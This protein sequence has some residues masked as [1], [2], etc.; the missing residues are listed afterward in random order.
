MAEDPNEMPS[1]DQIINRDNLLNWLNSRSGNTVDG[2]TK[3]LML[4]LAMRLF[5]LVLPILELDGPEQAEKHEKKL[6]LQSFRAL[7]TTRAALT[8]SDFN[9]RP[10]LDNVNRAIQKLKH[11]DQNGVSSCAA[12]LAAD[13][14]SCASYPKGQSGT[15]NRYK[16]Y[17]VNAAGFAINL[18]VEAASKIE[19]SGQAIQE[20]FA[21][22]TEDVRVIQD[23]GAA[24]D[25]LKRRLWLNDVRSHTPRRQAHNL[26]DWCRIPFN[27]FQKNRN[28]KGQPWEKIVEWYRRFLAFDE[29]KLRDGFGETVELGI[30]QLPDEIWDGD[31]DEA[32]AQIADIVDG[33]LEIPKPEISTNEGL[34]KSKLHEIGAGSTAISVDSAARQDLLNRRAFADQLCLLLQRLHREQGKALAAINTQRAEDRKPPVKGDGFA[35]NLYAPWGAGKTSI[36]YMMEDYFT[37]AQR[38]KNECW[39]AV[40]FNAWRHERRNPPW[41]PL[42]EAIYASRRHHMAQRNR[43]LSAA[44]LFLRWHASNFWAVAG[45]YLIAIVIFAITLAALIKLFGAGQGIDTLIKIVAAT[46]SALGAFALFG[47]WF[48]HGSAKSAETHVEWSKDPMKRIL[49]LFSVMAEKDETPI[50]VFIDDLDRC[51]KDYV[52]DLLEGVQSAFRHHNVVYVIAAD[53]NWIRSAFEKRYESFNEHVSRPGQPLGYLFLE[54]IFQMSIPVPGIDDDMKQ[55]FVNAKAN[56]SVAMRDE[57]AIDHAT[58]EHSV[59]DEADVLEELNRSENVTADEVRGILKK[60]P[61]AKTKEKAA[62]VYNRSETA[63]E[64][65]HELLGRYARYLPDNPRLMVRLVNTFTMRNIIGFLEEDFFTTDEVLARWLVLEQRYP[66]IADLL[67]DHPEW[68]DAIGLEDIPDSIKPYVGLTALRE[69]IDDNAGDALTEDRVRAITRGSRV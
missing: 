4:R 12:E 26:P 66:E 30:A 41:W 24:D 35:V 14:A 28:V 68:I 7:L 51:N 42:I 6:V 47:R 23:G 18:M 13:A 1:S 60:N 45:P 9:F 63:R 52:I 32:M 54:K 48:V 21:S 43:K 57:S 40:Q 58:G 46:L 38:A 29:T 3:A 49:G 44:L 20:L 16:E 53:K 17:F 11:I 8:Y 62:E 50:C 56:G 69:I 31:P 64:E 36:L 27:N 37:A 34:N 2:E 22:I 15:A 5:P 55:D 59:T 67:T 65:Q 25:L 39:A 33:K 61:T 10:S 19:D